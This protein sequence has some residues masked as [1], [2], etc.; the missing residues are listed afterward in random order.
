MHVVQL[1]INSNATLSTASLRFV[2]A[3]TW[4]GSTQ[5]LGG[6]NSFTFYFFFVLT[7]EATVTTLDLNE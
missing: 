2:L 5:C 1:Y 7:D 6:K 4:T 3:P